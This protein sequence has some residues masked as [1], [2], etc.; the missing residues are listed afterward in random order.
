MSEICY[1]LQQQQ[2]KQQRQTEVNAKSIR[3]FPN[4]TKNKK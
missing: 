1:Q 4:D 3:L 2:Q